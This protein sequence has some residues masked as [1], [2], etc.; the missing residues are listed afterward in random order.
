MNSNVEQLEI[1]CPRC[2][3]IFADWYH[4]VGHGTESGCPRCGHR[5]TT[6]QVVHREGIWAFVPDIDDLVDR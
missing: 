4:P 6:D 3:E 5:P 2:G 1:V